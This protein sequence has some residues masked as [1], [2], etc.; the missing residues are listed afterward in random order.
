MS[1][2]PNSSMTTSSQE[3]P[4]NVEFKSPSNIDII[5]ELLRHGRCLDRLHLTSY[6]IICYIINCSSY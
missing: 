5:I 1:L 3:P 2:A 4:K 6:M